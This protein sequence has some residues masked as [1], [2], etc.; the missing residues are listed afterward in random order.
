[1]PLNEIAVRDL[2]KLAGRDQ[3]VDES[4]L[5]IIHGQESITLRAPSVAAKRKWVNTLEE[6]CQQYYVAEKQQTEGSWKG[7]RWAYGAPI[8]TLQVLIAEA[9]DLVR[10]D[11]GA[12][13]AAVSK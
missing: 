13:D 8:G 5:Q 12:C 1:M 2:S 7:G 4:C 6:Q 10:V 9:K 3:H 11:R